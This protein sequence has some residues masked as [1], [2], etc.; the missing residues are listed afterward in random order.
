MAIE[1]HPA[2]SYI[3]EFM[4]VTFRD[5]AHLIRL[6]V[7]V[8]AGI[9]VFFV[10]RAALVPKAFGQYGHYRPGSLDDI[11]KRPITY[12]GQAECV[13]C[14][15]DQADARSKGKH[16]HISCEACHGPQARHLE[17]A[18]ANKPK[19]PA[20]TALCTSCHEKDSAKPKWFPQVLT[21]DHSSGMDCN[22][23]HKPHAPKIQ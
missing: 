8:L 11:R 2:L 18:S 15:G 23:C 7:V 19:L 6:V 4:K 12:A 1:L 16:A 21:A 17:D 22:T 14:H 9:G 13:V 5:A 20:V 3:G 10:L